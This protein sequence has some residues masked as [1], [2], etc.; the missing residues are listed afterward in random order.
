MFVNFYLVTIYNFFI[1]LFILLK[2]INK[3]AKKLLERTLIKQK[4]AAPQ[5]KPLITKLKLLSCVND[6]REILCLKGS[7]ADKTAVNVFLCQKLFSVTC[8]H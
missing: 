2:K 7:A 3:S 4:K 6:N 8:V 1:N 5:R